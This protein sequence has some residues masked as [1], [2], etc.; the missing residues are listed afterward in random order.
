M[1]T[2]PEDHDL[3]RWLD[4]EMNDADRAAFEKRLDAEP[5]LKAE[6][7]GFQ[8]LGDGLRDALPKDHPLP[9]ADF[10]NSQIQVRI[11]QMELDE[12][13]AAARPAASAW[14]EWFR[15]PWLAAATAAVVALVAIVSRP[16]S[17]SRVIASDVTQVLS[18]Y[19]PNPAVVVRGY[20][21]AEAQATVLMLDGLPEVPA[22]Q[23]IV[24][25]DVHGSRADKAMASVTLLGSGGQPLVVLAKDSRNQPRVWD[26][27]TR[28]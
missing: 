20:E 4:G 27:T 18:T 25:Y 8:K 5:G 1:K 16:D 7:E 17:G 3:I 15:L 6:L 23:K 19:A 10:F 22:D 28:G 12:E 2:P 11:A 14:T 21:D 9:H 26:L 24:G 13:R